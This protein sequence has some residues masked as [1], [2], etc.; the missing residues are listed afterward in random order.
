MVYKIEEEVL[1]PKAVYK[2]P[3]SEDS[4]GTAR[5]EFGMTR[6]TASPSLKIMWKHEE[7]RFL[8]DGKSIAIWQTSVSKVG[9]N[10]FCLTYSFNSVN[11]L[12]SDG[13]YVPFS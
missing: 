7:N 13:V 2:S 6:A 12:L 11:H 1:S 8:H 9:Y 3:G 5:E 10:I 4:Q